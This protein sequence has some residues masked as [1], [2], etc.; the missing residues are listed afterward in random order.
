[1][2]DTM[3]AA[4]WSGVG[5][6]ENVVRPVPKPKDGETL[7]KIESVESFSGFSKSGDREVKDSNVFSKTNR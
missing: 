1:M 2:P 7:L 4:I 3:K 5:K 6:V